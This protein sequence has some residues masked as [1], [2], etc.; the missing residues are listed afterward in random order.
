MP[1]F[2]DIQFVIITEIFFLLFIFGLLGGIIGQFIIPKNKKNES[3]KKLFKKLLQFSIAPLL[4]FSFLIIFLRP[5]NMINDLA[6]V[7]ILLINIGIGITILIAGVNIIVD[8]ILL[9][10]SLFIKK[11]KFYRKS[12][13]ILLVF[14]FSWG[15]IMQ[16]LISF[17]TPHFCGFGC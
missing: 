10:S 2:T 14:S 11:L 16:L 3:R 5:Q 8:I 13:V 7:F 17:M 12:L 1:T 9:L 4:I 6:G 15:F